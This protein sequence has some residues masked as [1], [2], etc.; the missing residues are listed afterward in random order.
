MIIN[1]QMESGPEQNQVFSVMVIDAI[2]MTMGMY[3]KGTQGFEKISHDVLCGARRPPFHLF[4]RKGLSESR[5]TSIH[6]P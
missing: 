3:K 4:V 6:N 1:H 5:N 2:F